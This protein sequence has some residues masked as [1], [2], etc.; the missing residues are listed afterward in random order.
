MTNISGKRFSVF[1]FFPRIL[2]RERF[3]RPIFFFF[4]LLKVQ[5]VT[6]YLHS[7]A[8][9]SVAKRNDRNKS[10]GVSVYISQTTCQQ[11]GRTCFH[12]NKMPK[13]SFHV[14]SSI[15]KS[16]KRHP[17]VLY[18]YRLL[19]NFQPLRSIAA[20]IITKNYYSR[21]LRY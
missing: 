8:M 14:T 18:Y 11:A 19:L 4:S 5:K 20:C 16:T 21:V 7:L 9:Q 12:N 2:M 1:L 6:I 13:Q 10:T 17:S 3:Y 15:N